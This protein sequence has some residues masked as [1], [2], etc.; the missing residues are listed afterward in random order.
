MG[1]ENCRGGKP[2]I[3]G[4][5]CHVEVRGC[6]CKQG[7]RKNGK[8]CIHTECLLYAMLTCSSQSLGRCAQA[9]QAVLVLSEMWWRQ[10]WCWCGGTASALPSRQGLCDWWCSVQDGAT[11]VKLACVAFLPQMCVSLQLL[12]GKQVS[13]WSAASIHQ[14]PCKARPLLP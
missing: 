2:L 14:A 13:G 3:L 1:W 11:Q 9:R 6:A 7:N 5:T 12:L 8:E 4:H 10:H